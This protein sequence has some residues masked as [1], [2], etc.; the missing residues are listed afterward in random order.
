MRWLVVQPGPNFSVHDVYIGW[1]E[2]LRG[3]GQQVV[4]YNLAD[5]LAFY[6][7]VL[8]ERHG[9]V[10]KAL[11]D[12]QQV[13]G[14]AISGLSALL[15]H[16][17]P[18]VLLVIS[19]F[20]TPHELLDE[21]RAKGTL[22]VVVH[23][24]SPYE[25]S[26]QLRLAEHADVNLV[27]DP[28]HIEAFRQIQPNSFYAHHCYRPTVH[29]PGLAR[30]ELMSDFVFVG[31][32]Y[33]SRMDFLERM[34]LTGLNVRL[35]GNWQCVPDDSPLR[36]YVG[37]DINE[38]VDNADA[39][40]LYRSSRAGINMY[41]REAEAPVLA[42]GLAMGPREVEMAASGL[43]FLRDPRPEGDAVLHMLPTFSDPEEAGEILRWWLAHEDDRVEAAAKAREAV[44]DRTFTN[45]A[46]GLLRAMEP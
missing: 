6:D 32:G 31:T 4:E 46:A 2:A 20:F 11:K 27:N 35:A 5:R 22:V 24:E 43:F 36:P 16:S 42:Q 18:D 8:M 13:S 38:C 19:G 29:S 12:D 30:P 3:L 26:R 21:A 37:H 44:S 40:E 25:E 39:V 1:V 14:M 23:T 28:V 33:A 41:R 17:K 9:V 15:Y 7:N 10:E 34:G 45:L